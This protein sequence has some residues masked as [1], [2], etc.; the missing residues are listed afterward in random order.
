MSRE[1]LGSFRLHQW[2][3]DVDGKTVEHR[4][5]GNGPIPL[6]PGWMKVSVD[7]ET[8]DG[9]TKRREGDVCS[10]DCAGAFTEQAMD[11]GDAQAEAT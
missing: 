8:D 9:R 3:C 10:A 11:P 2:T 7:I 1:S 6:P 5:R 4:S